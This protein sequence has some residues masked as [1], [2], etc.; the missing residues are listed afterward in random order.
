[1]FRTTLSRTVPD[2]AC[3][4]SSLIITEPFI[5]CHNQR[6]K[7]EGGDYLPYLFFPAGAGTARHIWKPILLRLTFSYFTTNIWV[8]I[9]LGKPLVTSK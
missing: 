5:A 9:T 2:W 1:M 3:R 6:D 4:Y 7:T 8:L